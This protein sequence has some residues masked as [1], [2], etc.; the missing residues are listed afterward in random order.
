M[1]VGNKEETHPVARLWGMGKK[2]PILQRTLEKSIMGGFRRKT[3][4]D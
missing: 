2:Q 4:P 3:G 1:A